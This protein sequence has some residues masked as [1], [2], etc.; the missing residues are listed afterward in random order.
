M[1]KKHSAAQ[2]RRAAPP[3]GLSARCVLVGVA[4]AFA[5]ACGCLAAPTAHAQEVSPSEGV[6]SPA[7]L[8]ADELVLLTGGGARTFTVEIADDPMERQ[9][10]LMFRTELP[11]DH[12][13]LFDFVAEGARSFWMKNTPLP[14][15]IIYARADGTIVSIAKNTTPYSTKGIPSEGP[16]R[17]VL[18]VNAGI[19]DEIGLV[20]GDRLVHPRVQR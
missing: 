10:G 15:D 12:G 1:F 2:F 18:E 4:L 13:M 7:T 3:V 19:A 17:F 9:L 5:F 11:R 14:L 16:A 6:P 8:R 20:P